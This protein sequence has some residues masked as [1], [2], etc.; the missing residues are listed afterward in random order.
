MLNQPAIKDIIVFNEPLQPPQ[1]PE[2]MAD[3]R[4]AAVTNR[5]YTR[6]NVSAGDESGVPQTNIPQ[7]QEPQ[8]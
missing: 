7:P 3:Q 8:T 1:Q 5:T 2:L 4:K 6:R